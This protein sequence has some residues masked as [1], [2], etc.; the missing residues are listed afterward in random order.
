MLNS[1]ILTSYLDEIFISPGC[2]LHN[3]K[4]HS[5]FC[6]GTTKL[7]FLSSYPKKN[8]IYFPA[9]QPPHSFYLQPELY[10]F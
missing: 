10:L 3:F 6:F 4:E 9:L 2:I 7:V 5:I 1:K 8:E